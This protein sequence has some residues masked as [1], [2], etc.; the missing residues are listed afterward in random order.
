MTGPLL[1]RRSILLG[2]AALAGTARAQRIVDL[3]LPGGPSQRPTSSAWPQ[4]GEMIVQRARPPL[5]ETPFEV[6]GQGVFTP[7][8]RFFVRWHWGDIPTSI[9]AAAFRLNV[10]G[11]VARPLSLSL[12]ELMAM[13]RIE[14][15]A[16]NQCSGNSR[17]YFEPRVLGAQWGHG[18][19]SN[20]KWT[21]VRLKDV[22]DRAGVQPGAVAVRFAGLDQPLVPDG[23]DFMKS[24]D[25]DHARDGE[26]MI[27]FLQNGEPLPLLNGFPLRVIVPGW[28]STYW[29]KMLSDIEVL[30]APDDNFWMAKAYRIP[31]TPGANVAP[32]A[33]GFATKP[34][35]RMI[36]RSWI[37]SH[38]DGARVTAGRPLPVRGIAM[39]GDAGVKSVA[40]SVD[41]GRSWADASLGRDEGK[42][43]FRR[44]EAV[45]PPPAAGALSLLPR[46]TSTAGVTQSMEPIW[47]GGGYLRGQVEPTRIMVA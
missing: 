38:A 41:G 4:K 31:D 40:L 24:L 20:A 19:M 3:H 30:T 13:P 33:K 21:G 47:N 16:V 25:L 10:R 34:I 26:V 14:Y 9:D 27:A 8:D 11:H 36:P 46:C 22:L 43:S 12:D 35:S 44:F 7:N 1:P 2:A 5:L 39:G 28:F 42:Y 32:G 37:T 18:A 45:L 23:P 17:G 6:F 29:M 15:A